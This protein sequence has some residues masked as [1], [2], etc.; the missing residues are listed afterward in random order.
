MERNSKLYQLRRKVQV[1]AEKMLPDEVLSKIYCKI[2]VKKWPNLSN[3]QTFNEKMQ[4]YKLNYCPFNQKVIDCADKYKVR[5]YIEEKGYGHLLNE[6]LGVWSDAKDISWDKLPNKFVLK[7]NH[8]CAYNIVCTDKNKL[9]KEKTIK[10]LNTWLKEDFGVYN[11][12]KHYS[13]I[14]EKKIICEEFL[15]EKITDYKFYCFNQKPEFFY[16]SN[17]LINDRQAKIGFYDLKGEKLPLN[18]SDYGEIEDTPLPEYFLEMK[19]VARNL[20]REFPFVRVDF[21]ITEGKYCFAELTF[22]P[23]AAMM[24]I[25]P[26]KYDKYWGDLLIIPPKV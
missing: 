4:F 19:N 3:P 5:K 16:V 10:Q 17:D 20:A 14:E 1:I 23:A 21:F 24:P 2:I 18:R 25:N 9:D 11:I 22:T 8:G 13:K 15:G 12:E 26:I 7:C 6:L